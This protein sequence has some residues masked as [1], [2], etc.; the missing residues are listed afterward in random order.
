M[1][2]FIEII[3]KLSIVGLFILATFGYFYT[4]KPKYELDNLK[5]HSSELDKKN[6]ALKKEINENKI[7]IKKTQKEAKKSITLL[8]KKIK[9]LSIIEMK[10]NQLNKEINLSEK[11][12]LLIT[13]EKE[14]SLN[15]YKKILW[16]LYINTVNNIGYG[17]SRFE[18]VTK[19]NDETG[20]FNIVLDDEESNIIKLN[21]VDLKILNKNIAFNVFQKRLPTL[22]NKFIPK[23]YLNEFILFSKVFIENNKN[24]LINKELNKQYYINLMD[25]YNSDILKIENEYQKIKNEYNINLK[26]V[27]NE[28]SKIENPTQNQVIEYQN[29][30]VQL[31]SN[32]NKNYWAK[33]QEKHKNINKIKDDFH[34]KLEKE[35]MVVQQLID[36]VIQ[37]LDLSYKKVITK[38][39][40][41]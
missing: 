12:I 9:K 4:V 13:K 10:I 34:K 7:I 18:Y 36:N 40:S 16:N 23:N 5:I 2:E 11:N 1:K 37:K 19:F 26:K 21:I 24:Y 41:Q 29:K 3:S 6:I 20:Q 32:Y 39:S 17:N 38:Q 14:K 33:K 22:S 8:N 28:F 25:T 27:K 15:E 31:F 30:K 35:Y